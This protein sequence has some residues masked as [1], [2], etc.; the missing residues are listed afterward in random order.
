MA[1]GLILENVAIALGG[2]TLLKVDA[3]VQK[4]AVLTIMG[5]S[6]SG[7]SSLLAFIGGFLDP[8]F[9]ATGRVISDGKVA[10]RPAAAGAP[11]GHS[12]SGPAAV[13]AH[14]GWRQSGVCAVG[15]VQGQAG[16]A[17][18]VRVCAGEYRPWRILRPRSGL[19]FRRA[20]G[21]GG[22][23]AGAAFRAAR[24][25]CSTSHSP[26]ST[27]SCAARCASWCLTRRRRAACQLSS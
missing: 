24:A 20:E 8:V 14:V 11:C 13:S 7:K 15:A 21:A 5:P 16:A 25:A 17:G 2:K 1:D 6:G 10:D 23:G 3:H 22:A 4:G 9:T 27:W 18:A 12:V 19:A 26:S